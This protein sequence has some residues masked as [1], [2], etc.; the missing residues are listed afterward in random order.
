MGNVNSPSH[1][2]YG[3]PE[4]ID[5]IDSWGLAADFD[6]GNVLKYFLRAPYK[7]NEEEDYRK[8]MYYLERIYERCSTCKIKYWDSLT[9]RSVRA[10]VGKLNLDWFHPIRMGVSMTKEERRD[11]LNIRLGITKNTDILLRQVI[12]GWELE[13]LRQYFIE[14]FYYKNFHC[15]AC[16]KS[17]SDLID[18]VAEP[19]KE[20]EADIIN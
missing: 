10:E 14:Y 9:N 20:E 18:E 16:M 11:P 4:V 2:N 17:L 15:E 12:D 13:G 19:E 8:A 6:A 5:I 7:G 3:T 1:Y